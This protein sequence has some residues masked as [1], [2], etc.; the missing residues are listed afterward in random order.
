MIYLMTGTP[1]SGKS[2]HMAKIILS[3]AKRS[4]GIIAN[5]PVSLNLGKKLKANVLYC[6]NKDL[7]PDYFVQYAYN[8]HKKGVEG[9]TI[10]VIDEAQLVFNCRDFGK[11][12]RNDWV[13][14]FTQHRHMG[15]DVYLICQNDRMID[16][17]IRV[18]AEYEILHRCV[19]NFKTIGFLLRVLG[20][21][22]IAIE[23]WYGVK[24]SDGVVS[25]E[26]FFNRKSLHIY[27]SYAL[28]NIPVDQSLV[29]G[30][31]GGNREAVGPWGNRLQRLWSVLTKT[32]SLSFKKSK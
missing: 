2:L 14:F 19:N 18:L 7:S 13:K 29:A 28:F 10:I 26:I 5:Y 15:Y 4:G 8:H 3:R 32:R 9:Q 27:D 1:G 31:D 20:K 17:Q 12:D 30:G 21:S 25:K 24:G 16:K 6:D 23:R 22:F 11:K